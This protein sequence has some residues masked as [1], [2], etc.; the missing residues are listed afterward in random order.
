MKA[1]KYSPLILALLLLGG[2]ALAETFTDGKLLINETD[3]T[4]TPVVATVVT[5]TFS[6]GLSDT[7]AFIV[8]FWAVP[9]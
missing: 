8:D 2:W 7:N 1:L 5:N 3:P 9:D 6:F 4:V